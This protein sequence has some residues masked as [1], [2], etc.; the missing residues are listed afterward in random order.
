MSGRLDGNFKHLS[1]IE[2]LRQKCLMWTSSDAG[3]DPNPEF[4]VKPLVVFLEL[5]CHVQTCNGCVTCCV[6]LCGSR[7]LK[8]PG[9]SKSTSHYMGVP[10]P[11]DCATSQAI[12]VTDNFNLALIHFLNGVQ[13][14]FKPCFDLVEGYSLISRETSSLTKGGNL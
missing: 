3:A 10:L 8:Q 1:F 7:T 6:L 14:H 11:E 2:F 4:C 13:M 9:G 5:E 12:M